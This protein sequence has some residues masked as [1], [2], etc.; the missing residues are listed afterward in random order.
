M[1]AI[2]GCQDRG[3]AHAGEVNAGSGVVGS[4]PPAGIGHSAELGQ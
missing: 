2:P 3:P 1:D 4:Q